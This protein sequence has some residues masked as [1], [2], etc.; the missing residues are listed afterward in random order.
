MPCSR[1]VGIARLFFKITS[2]LK[3]FFLFFYLFSLYFAKLFTYF[4]RSEDDYEDDLSYEEE[5]DDEEYDQEE[6]EEEA[7]QIVVGIEE[8]EEVYRY[9]HGSKNNHLV[10]DIV[11]GGECLIFV[12]EKS[13]ETEQ[14]NIGHEYSSS[15][16]SVFEDPAEYF[17]DAPFYV[18]DCNTSSD[19][20]HDHGDDLA[21]YEVI[22]EVDT[23]TRAT[24]NPADETFEQTYDDHN[25]YDNYDYQHD[26][27]YRSQSFKDQSNDEGITRQ[28]P[29]IIELKEDG[30]EMNPEK[31]KGGIGE[32]VVKETNFTRDEKFLIFDP[33]KS[34]AKKLQIKEKEIFE[35]FE[36]TYTIGSTSKSSSEWRSS[37]PDSGTEDPFSSS[38]RRSC[39]KWESYTVYQK[40]DEEMM[41]LDRLSAQK[42][43]ETESLRSF[44]VEPRSISQRIVH[45]IA[46]K[47]KPSSEKDYKKSYRELEA[48]YVAQI[49]LAWEALNW[50]YANF[51]RKLVSREKEEE[52]RGCPAYIAQQFQQLQVLLQRYVENEPYERGRR[53]EIYA[54]MRSVAP[55][56]L[57][58]PEYHDYEGEYK[59]EVVD[60]RI[61]SASFLTILEEA[62]RTFMSFLKA[63]R[64]THC[65][66][67]TDLFKRGHK[68]SVDPAILRLL[69][70]HCK[71]KK[72]K[73]KELQS[74]CI[75]LRKRKIER[76]EEMEI[77]MA[78][79]DLQV[80]SRVLRM[81]DITQQ[82][83]QWCEAKMCKVTLLEGKLQ[84][85]SSPLFFPAHSPT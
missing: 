54:R 31:N 71:K 45:K 26:K 76:R 64:K 85:D 60:A 38:S 34:E 11:N 22:K 5:E 46:N 55:K 13:H 50:N 81:A 1:K 40:Y 78:L 58:V 2:V 53:P 62:I 3:F 47:Q 14:T 9:S 65:Q 68:R 18:E 32:E 19:Y 33:P 10:A 74:S 25:D 39:P 16:D 30:S 77:L 21:D 42:L 7:E 23:P 17:D 75:L 84:R 15:Y 61:A 57:Q 70:K 43:H 69:K 59:D 12:S 44:Q 51:Q 79:I 28:N 73:L 36:D 48:A 52:D 56:L 35:I 24:S 6:E 27:A 37:I 72:S 80:V 66:V 41:F 8:D 63:D 67:L 49:C 4:F 29:L 83:L 82:Q 20:E